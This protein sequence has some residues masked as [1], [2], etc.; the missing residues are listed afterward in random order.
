MDTLP[1]EICDHIACLLY[2]PRESLGL[3]DEDR[4]GKHQRIAHLSVLSRRWQPII[5]QRVFQTLNITSSDIIDLGRI[6]FGKRRQF[7]TSLNVL[8]YLTEYKREMCFKYESDGERQVD[9]ELAVAQLRRLFTLLST[10]DAGSGLVLCLGFSSPSDLRF[11]A[12]NERPF[13]HLERKRYQNSFI[14]IRRTSQ[15][16]E[17]KCVTQFSPSSLATRDMDLCS[18]LTLTHCFPRATS[19]SWSTRDPGILHL[20]RREIRGGLVDGAEGYSSK[21]PAFVDK[22]YVSFEAPDFWDKDRLPNLISPY[23]Y[24]RTSATLR[25]LSVSTKTFQYEGIADSTLFWPAPEEKAPAPFWSHLT[26]LDIELSCQSPSGRWYFTTLDET[27]PFH[28][29]ESEIP[30]PADSMHLAP[31]YG[32]AVETEEAVEY[33]DAIIELEREMDLHEGRE[34]FRTFPNEDVIGPVVESFSKA[35]AQMPV[36]TRANLRF[37]RQGNGNYMFLAY[38]A[39]GHEADYEVEP[40]GGE[41]PITAPRLA[42][43]SW[44]WRMDEGL[45]DS[46]QKAVLEIHGQE[47]VVAYL[48]SLYED[49]V[50]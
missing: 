9:N 3:L 34:W 38:G 12:I 49:D 50:D 26:D 4:R 46:F 37:C 16:P 13:E 6:V 47:V 44:D 48:P 32:S 30:L 11:R 40:E 35:L 2:T 41:L 5:E 1:T 45:K 43:F 18:H 25:K 27:N 33:E 23:S 7:L 29:P 36:L 21:L 20:L 15:L 28:S 22:F 19:V 14:T 10:W 39:P 24:D 42:V 31:G 17:V 8:I